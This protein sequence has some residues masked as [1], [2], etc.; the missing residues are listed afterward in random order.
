MR[1]VSRKPGSPTGICGSVMVPSAVAARLNTRRPY[2][3]T[4]AVTDVAAMR[5]AGASTTPTAPA[6]RPVVLSVIGAYSLGA[7]ATGVA[8]GQVP[9]F[10]AAAVPAPSIASLSR[11]SAVN[12]PADG[13]TVPR[14][15]SSTQVPESS[16]RAP[17]GSGEALTVT[18]AA[19]PAP[20]R[21]GSARPNELEVPS[22]FGTE[23]VVRM[24]SSEMS[25]AE[26]LTP[27]PMR[28]ETTRI[29][30]LERGSVKISDGPYCELPSCWSTCA[31][32]APIRVKVSVESGVP[33]RDD[34]V[35]VVKR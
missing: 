6:E 11:G 28:G 24:P 18:F 31:E 30:A 25:V 34:D 22:G 21:S 7:P 15:A 3:L 32:P 14:T 2:Q 5:P 10:T 26:L 19:K 8:G 20:R 17:D 9:R 4:V 35:L 33:T 29:A 1:T 27:P 16:G 23:S 12:A 13:P